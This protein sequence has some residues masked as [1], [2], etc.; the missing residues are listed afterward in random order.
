MITA[1]WVWWCVTACVSAYAS[2]IMC[3]SVCTQ[4]KGNIHKSQSQSNFA[5]TCTLSLSLSL[6]HT[7]THSHTHTLTHTHQGGRWTCMARGTAGWGGGH[8]A[9]TLEARG[10]V[11]RATPMDSTTACSGWSR[12][13]P[14]RCQERLFLKSTIRF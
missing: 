4:T 12:F 6:S 9:A 10:R 11:T 8:V 5:H 7:H 3:H 1:P 14:W 13:E 2:H